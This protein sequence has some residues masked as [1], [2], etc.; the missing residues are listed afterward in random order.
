[1]SI[2]AA[3]PEMLNVG[4]YHAFSVEACVNQIWFLKVA[5]FDNVE[6]VTPVIDGFV[7]VVPL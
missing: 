5:M 3:A 7:H 1:M 6:L 2:A 4:K